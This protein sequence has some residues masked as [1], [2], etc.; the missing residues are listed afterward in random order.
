M[1]ITK[2]LIIIFIMIVIFILAISI[3][4]GESYRIIREK[5]IA[6]NVSELANEILERINFNFRVIIEDL[7]L[8][9]L[10]EYLDSFFSKEKIKYNNKNISDSIYVSDKLKEQF[11]KYWGAN[12]GY[13]LF[14]NV[15]IID[16][17]GS[18]LSSTDNSHIHNKIDVKALLNEL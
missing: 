14:K 11:F 7:Y 18:I 1:T 4:L 6:L 5:T 2:K 15:H 17:N 12:R 16:L 9:S 3:Y 8:Y 13:Q 10:R